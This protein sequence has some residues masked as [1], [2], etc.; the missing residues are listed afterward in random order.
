MDTPNYEF[1]PVTPTDLP[2][3]IAAQIRAAINSGEL[4][5]NDKLPTESE[6][7]E[8]FNVSRP[9]IREALKRL[10]AQNLIRSRRGPGGGSFI[11]VPAVQEV[12]QELSTQ[13]RLLLG[14]QSI[15]ETELLEC[16]APLIQMFATLAIEHRTDADLEALHNALTAQLRY[17]DDPA[18]FCNADIAFHRTLVESAHNR[19]LSLLM[20][21][22][23]EGAQP[24]SNMV[25]FRYPQYARI[26]ELHEK[27]LAAM[28]HR[29]LAKCQIYL[30]ESHQMLAEQLQRA[31]SD[32]ASRQNKA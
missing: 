28:Q 8:R 32:Y 10:A 25:I 26:I 14:L 20:Y 5:A 4:N 23:I 16:R 22:L 19:L 18:Q 1:A 27:I 21:P 17:Q 7:A 30:T 13:T 9:T 31:Q 29:A 11:T 6:L 3:Q 15:S 24:V 12:G 2:K